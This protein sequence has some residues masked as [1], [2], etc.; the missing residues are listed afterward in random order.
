MPGKKVYPKRSGKVAPAVKSYVKKQMRSNSELKRFELADQEKIEGTTTNA[1]YITDLCT[2]AE[3]TGKEERIGSEIKLQGVQLKGMFHNNS[4]VVNY[5]RYVIGYFTQ[6]Q[7]SLLNTVTKVFRGPFDQQLNTQEVYAS[8]AQ[9]YA[10]MTT[11][12]HPE[13]F[14]TLYDKVIKIGPNTSTDGTNSR[15][16]NKFIKLHNKKVSFTTSDVPASINQPAPRLVVMR[17]YTDAGQDAGAVL[18][19]IE[20][21]GRSIVW[22]RDS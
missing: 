9:P 6:N 7:A 22:Y 21:S 19:P 3:G 20:Y 8:G 14:H 10:L 1:N 12:L 16:F 4:S 18:Q 13:L 17:M 2:I 15:L 5:V 11:P